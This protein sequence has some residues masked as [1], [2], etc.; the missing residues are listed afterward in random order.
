MALF[1]ISVSGVMTTMPTPTSFEVSYMDISKAERNSNGLML[2]E[3]IT[4][5][6]KIQV[7]YDFLI[8]SDMTK[9]LNAVAPTYYDVK[10]HDPKTNALDTANMY[11]GDRSVSFIDYINGTP[12][13]RGVSF[14]LIER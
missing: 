4:T 7:S 2:I 3:R 8:A 12:R 10:F 11:C 14:D 9:I 6:R 13:Y 5:K 1:S